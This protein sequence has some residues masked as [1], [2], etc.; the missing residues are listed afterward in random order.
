M[1]LGVDRVLL[2]DR[3]LVNMLLGWIRLKIKCYFV[4]DLS[5]DIDISS[6][7][8]LFCMK[9]DVNG[10]L[11][12]YDFLIFYIIFF[13]K[14]IYIIFEIVVVDFLDVCVSFYKDVLI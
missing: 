8:G 7:D 13:I 5:D 11:V 9:L 6:S 1:I 14:N 10:K 3:G 12:F 2:W 4:V